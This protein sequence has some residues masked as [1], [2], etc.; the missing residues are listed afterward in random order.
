MFA[1][2]FD[3]GLQSLKRSP[4]SGQDAVG[5]VPQNGLAVVLGKMLPELSQDFSGADG[6]DVSC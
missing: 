5:T 6:F 1:L 3:G 2:V 4:S